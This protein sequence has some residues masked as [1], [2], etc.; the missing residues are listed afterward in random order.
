MNRYKSYMDRV[1]VTQAFHDK[2]LNL[3]DQTP[4]RTPWAK[5]TAAA[6]CA[7]LLLGVGAFA[8]GR[9]QWPGS[10]Q[11][12][13]PVQCAVPSAPV[14]SQETIDLAPAG[15]DE[16]LEPGMKTI[17]GYEVRVSQGG[18]EAVEYHVLP[19]IDYGTESNAAAALDWDIPEG[20]VRRDLSADEITALLG[21]EEAVSQHLDWSGYELTGWAAW[22]GDGSFWG[23]YLQGC[24]GPLDHF[25]FAVTAGQL[26]PTCVVFGGSVEQE[27]WGVRVT[28]DKYDGK[29]GCARRVS[30]LKD[31][32][33][34][35]FDLTATSGPEEA[36]KLVS[37]VVTHVAAGDGL[38]FSLNLGE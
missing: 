36:E 7:A 12:P 30:F 2:L 23:A 29:E 34:Y 19:W 26:P 33:G 17:E 21:G 32:Y 18:R 31:N 5:Y 9:A 15:P 27:I 20:S 13:D 38:N 24:K 6:A 14:E 11:D 3:A 1:V 4:T 10:G 28:A 37:R 25:E 16:L 8:L 35:R 22:N